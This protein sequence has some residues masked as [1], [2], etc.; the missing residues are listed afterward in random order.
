MARAQP[1]IYS[2]NGGEVG[3]ESV[4][5]LDLE[6]MRFSGELYENIFPKVIGSFQFRGGFAYRDTA[7][8]NEAN[9]AFLKFIVGSEENALLHFSSDG[10]RIFD[11]D[12]NAY[13][14]R[15]SVTTAINQPDFSATGSWTDE[16]DSGATATISG[17]VVTLTATSSAE[18]RIRQTV[19]V[20]PS[21][22]EHG[23][24]LEVTVGPVNLEIGTT[25]GGSEILGYTELEEGFHSL[26]FTPNVSTMYVQ[27]TNV[28]N[29]EA[30]VTRCGIASSGDIVVDHPWATSDLSSLK[31]SQSSDV[32][33]VAS[34]T[35]QQR[36]IERRDETSWSIVRY[37]TDDGPFDILPDE[38]V[39]ITPSGT[40]GNI[41]L[42]ASEGIFSADD[43]GSLFRLIQYSQ[44]VETTFTAAAQTSD[45]IIVTG[46]GSADRAFLGTISG[47]YVGQISLDRSIGNDAGFTSYSTYTGT[48]TDSSFDDGLNNSTVYYRWRCVSLTSGSVDVELDY[49][50]GVTYGIARITAYNSTTVLQAE[51]LSQIAEADSTTQW[52]RGTWSDRNG[53]P[54]SVTLFDGRLW[55][56]RGDLVYGSISDSFDS[57]DDLSDDDLGDSAP[58]VRSINTNTSNGI[59]WLLGLQRLAAGTARAEISIR[60]SSFDE[61]ITASN[62]VPR[63]A[64]SRGSY[65]LQPVR[66]DSEAVYVQRSGTRAYRFAYDSGRNDYFSYDLTKFHREIIQEGVV[67]MDVQRHPDTRIWFLLANGEARVL[68]LEVEEQVMAWTRVTIPDAEIEDIA[69]LPSNGEDRVFALVKRTI[70]SATV[71]YI[72]EMAPLS[73]SIGGTVNFMADS[74]VTGTQTASTTIS[75]LDHLEGEDVIVWA[76][77]VALHDK[78]NTLTVASGEI[79][80]SAAVTDYVV[81]LPYMGYWTST[82][83]AYGSDLGT[84]LTQR[85]RVSHLGLVM[86]NVALDGIRIG[87]SFATAD[88]RKVRQEKEG[89]QIDGAEVLSV[90]NYDATSFAGSWAPDTRV[91]I[92]MSAPYPATIA[93]LV[94]SMKTKDMAG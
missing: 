59:L 19:T 26:A 21:T 85:K 33:F 9:N 31:Y 78:D 69:I 23:L 93:A 35:Y 32:L 3:A 5:R 86:N 25:A 79:T 34:N 36:R 65:D 89:K 61:P 2:L 30:K 56:G 68:V 76:D 12:T 66:V 55:W 80:C 20:S 6:K 49:E 57:Y 64:S 29:K 50:G 46:S 1:A 67:R 27:I 39:S 88:L 4:Q 38:S 47:T 40:S 24:E 92:Q 70:D 83:L 63:T 11:A 71:R 43:V 52:D 16:S 10:M 60:A 15:A 53:W 77:G 14:E 94:L 28:E 22:T 62:F 8:V 7:P 18:A 84:A 42:T 45:S 81:G 87:K 44:F 41:T 58:V 37:K 90:Y 54:T 13:L 82:D 51:V 72:E 48:F 74:Y 73:E 17:G 91:N 75:G